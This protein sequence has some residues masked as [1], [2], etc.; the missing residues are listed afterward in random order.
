MSKYPKKFS[1]NLEKSSKCIEIS[2]IFV[3]KN[4]PILNPIGQNFPQR[5]VKSMS[6]IVYT[7]IMEI[8]QLSKQ[9]GCKV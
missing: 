2:R 6:E 9:H 3:L 5:D 1:K 7:R 4:K 8:K